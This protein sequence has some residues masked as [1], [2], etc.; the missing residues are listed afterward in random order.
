MFQ[1][2][3]SLFGLCDEIIIFYSPKDSCQLLLM[4]SEP[5]LE[6]L[7]SVGCIGL[8]GQHL[9][10]ERL[11]INPSGLEWSNVWRR[12]LLQNERGESGI[13]IDCPRFDLVLGRLG[14]CHVYPISSVFLRVDA[15][16][17]GQSA[18]PVELLSTLMRRSV[19]SR[20]LAE[21]RPS[22]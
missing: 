13:Y 4:Q 6:T 14:G 11:I 20:V 2:P 15:P 9:H 18:R 3:V 7:K 1:G 19:T 5:S 10:H 17:L 16:T 8:R 22:F 21:P 12:Q